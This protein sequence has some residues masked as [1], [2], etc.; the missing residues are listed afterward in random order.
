[1]LMQKPEK[2]LHWMARWSEIKT[3][4][5]S[6][7]F[8]IAFLLQ[9]VSVHLSGPSH[10]YPII[11]SNLEKLI[12][13]NVCLAFKQTVCGFD[14][15]RANGKSYVCDVNGFSFV[16]N[17]AKYYDDSAKIMGNMIL[18]ALAPQLRIPWSIPFQL[19]DPPIVETTFGKMMELC[20][21]IA[22]I[23]HSDRTPKQKMKMEVKD[24]R[25]FD[26]FEKNGGYKSGHVKLKRPRQL[27]EILD[28]A[29]SLLTEFESSDSN[30][31]KEDRGKLDQLK[32]ILEMYG[33]F[34]GINRK[35]QLKYQQKESHK[36][37][38]LV[39][40]MKWWAQLS[41]PKMTEYT[42]SVN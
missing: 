29:R 23:R 16:K 36:E 3:A 7:S 40:I 41:F 4:K 10:R 5:R 22:I 39:L 8:E 38:S 32:S 1:M 37:P 9:T 34:S 21:A 6:G 30:E 24:K 18:R 2:V 26:I 20:C 33:H 15:L 14:L 11:L 19:D 27:Q 35:I 25:F 31:I 13:R 28:I 17:S 12:A 42:K